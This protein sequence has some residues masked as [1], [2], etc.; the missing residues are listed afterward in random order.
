MAS[1]YPD[2]II[3]EENGDESHNIQESNGANGVAEGD[4]GDQK[5]TRN[6]DDD[7][8]VAETSFDHRE[9][10]KAKDASEVMAGLDLFDE[11]EDDDM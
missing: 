1:M 10:S 11:D 3:S 9:H 7:D 6:Q 4:D 2:K 8:D 5:D